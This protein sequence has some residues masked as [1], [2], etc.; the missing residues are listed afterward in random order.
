MEKINYTAAPPDVVIAGAANAL[1]KVEGMLA[2][3]VRE[4]LQLRYENTDVPL[5]AIEAVGVPCWLRET[6]AN[7]T[8]QLTCPWWTVSIM[9]NHRSFQVRLLGELTRVR[10]HAGLM[11]T[12]MDKAMVH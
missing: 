6:P 9:N 3:E 1:Q 10:E 7:G 2:P 5:V 12:P 11:F 4:A 8:W